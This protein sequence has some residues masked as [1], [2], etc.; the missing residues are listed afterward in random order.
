MIVLYII[1]NNNSQDVSRADYLRIDLLFNFKQDFKDMR[2]FFLLM[3][4]CYV[5]AGIVAQTI[6][7]EPKLTNTQVGFHLNVDSPFRSVMPEMQTTGVWGFSLAH[8]PLMGS[9]FYI[10]FKALFGNYGCRT[11]RDTYY[12]KNNWWY[13]AE[14]YYKSGY[15]KFLLGPKFMLG[16]D[17]R[18]IRG[19]ATPQIGLI[20]MRSKTTVKYWDGSTN[21]NNNDTNDDGSKQVSKTAIKQTSFGYGGEIGAEFYLQR[22]FKKSETDNFRIQLSGSFLRGFKEFRYSN[23]DDMVGPEHFGDEGV[24]FGNYVMVSHPN[25]EEINYVKIEQ[26]PLQLWG[27]NIGLTINF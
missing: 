9:P 10:E 3:L 11:N 19:F 24:D 18:A 26:S 7:G 12:L 16:S 25:A 8:S 15:Q 13:P 6:D 2:H 1:K 17:F 23:V 5:N 22:L 27:I 20:R 21:W 4:G 14:S